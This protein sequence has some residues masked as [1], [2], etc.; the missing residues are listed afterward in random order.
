MARMARWARDCHIP[1]NSSIYLEGS[2]IKA[3]MELKFNLGEGVAHLSSADKDL[4]IMA[5]RGR[6]SAEMERIREQEE[7]LLATKNTRQLDELLRLSK[8]V[9]RAPADNFWE[10][11]SNI[12]E[13]PCVGA[14]RVRMGLLQ[15]PT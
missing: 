8:G 3:I 15:G 1:I 10:L 6:T 13:C 7:A 11:K 5:C 12:A 4:T 14:I 2:T 9:T